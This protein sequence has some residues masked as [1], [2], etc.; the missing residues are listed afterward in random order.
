MSSLLP[1]PKTLKQQALKIW[2]RAD[3]HRAWLQKNNYFP[4]EIPL[5]NIPAKDLLS[6]FTEVQDAIYLLRQ[7][8][9]KHD[10]LIS[11][12]LVTHRQLGEQKIPS[13]IIF[14]TEAVFLDYVAKSAE[15]I[16]FKKLTQRT[17]QQ[18][19]LLLD[20]V[21]RYPFK[22]MKHADVWL[23]LLKVC[24]Y[25]KNQPQPDC[26][27]RQLNIE[28]VDSKF[29]EQHKGILNELL[30]Q[31]LDETNY[32]KEITGLSHHGFE[33]RY[34]LRYDQ[35]LIRLRILDT[36]LA[37]HGLTD[38]TLTISEF[39]QLNIALKTVFIAENKVNGLA[40][41]DYPEAIVIFGLGYAVDLLDKANCLQGKELYY[42]GDLDT[43]GFAILSRLR[44]Y[45]PQAKSML[46]DQTTLELFADL[47][48]PE[49]KKSSEQGELS[50]LTRDENILY[51]QLQKSLCRLEQER[52][53]FNYLQQYLSEISGDFS[54]MH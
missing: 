49:P 10:Y 14:K 11:D 38:L 15:F 44:H 7:D 35:S 52:I 22:I 43:H 32:D 8:S 31:S 5:K 6:N 27:I 47:C 23:Q 42:W 3:I 30:T 45:F 46:M 28:G 2:Q 25:F 21:N 13:V 26:Y 54:F 29:I 39:K 37:I 40:F 50:H 24:D 20:W 18:D 16:Q 4:L 1:T 34:S 41:P 48:V 36:K 12:K 17:L 51:K 9:K 33:R 53:G 19:V